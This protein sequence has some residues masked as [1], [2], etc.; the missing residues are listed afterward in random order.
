MYQ[1]NSSLFIRIFCLIFSTT[2]LL[3]IPHLLTFILSI[4]QHI[5][6][7]FLLRFSNNVATVTLSFYLLCSALSNR[8]LKY[9]LAYFILNINI[10][11][12]YFYFFNTLKFISFVNSSDAKFNIFVNKKS[13]DLWVYNLFL[14]FLLFS[15][16][17]LWLNILTF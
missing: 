15:V 14:R 10:D 1:H 2:A 3:V 8:R 12:S 13:T 4:I 16:Y 6:T 9:F 7:C 17:F 5:H 11:Q